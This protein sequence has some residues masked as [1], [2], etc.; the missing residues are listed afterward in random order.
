MSLS[1]DLWHLYSLEA[2][3]SLSVESCEESHNSIES[4]QKQLALALRDQLRALDCSISSE[5]AL[6]EQISD[7]REVRATYRERLLATE[8]SLADARREIEALRLKDQEQSRRVVDLETGVAK[9]QSRSTEVSQATLRI[10]ELDSRNRDLQ[11]EVVTLSKDVAV[12][13]DQLQQRSTEVHDLTERSAVVQEKFKAATEETARSREEKLASER[14]AT[15]EREQLRDELSKAASM[16]LAS[17]ESEHMN[18]IQQL[19]LEKLQVEEKL[20][21]VSKQNDILRAEKE[22][23]EKELRQLQALLKEARNETEA[24]R[25]TRKALELH[26]SEMQVRMDDKNIQCGEMQVM[27]KK[28]ND[29]VR[30]KD[31]EIAALRA[32]QMTRIGSSGVPGRNNL[33][34]SAGGGH[35]L[36]QRPQQDQSPSA[37]PTSSRSSKHFTK[38][39]SVVED[40]QPTEKP[41][42]VSLDDLMLEDPFADYAQEGPHTIA[43]E[44]IS[45][46]FP[47]TP[48]TASQPKDVDLTRKSVFHTTVVSETQRTQHHSIHKPTPHTSNYALI[49]A[50]SQPQ[51]RAHFKEGKTNAMPRSSAGTSTTKSNTSHRESNNLTSAREVSIPRDSTQSQGSVKDPRQGKRNSLAAGFDDANRLA[52]PSK[53][54][55][56]APTRPTRALGPVIEDSQS[57]PF[58]GR[59]RKMTRKRSNAPKGETLLRRC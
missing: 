44:D 22:K 37:R 1:P 42:F 26:L 25:G 41:S 49:K 38:R 4:G 21:S 56:A 8:S 19:K 13:S 3:I 23:A 54:H 34:R 59:G 17:V 12:L 16:Q 43:G 7:L 20:Q 36:H 24:V 33:V 50:H 53:I 9:A 5:H 40:S 39:L 47:S 52:R 27:L 18:V 30:A 2:R 14:T 48:G 32:S 29:Q 10:Q 15:F 35:A 55:R 31:L 58:N 46:L 45:H 51:P 57:P 11:S 28:A 6:T